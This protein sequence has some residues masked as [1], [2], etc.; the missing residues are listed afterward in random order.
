MGKFSWLKKECYKV[1][2]S[3]TEHQHNTKLKGKKRRMEKRRHLLKKVNDALLTVNLA[4][5]TNENT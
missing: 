1:F 3:K 2:I 4:I 5:K